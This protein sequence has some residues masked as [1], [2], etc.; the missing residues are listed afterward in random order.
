MINKVQIADSSALPVR[1]TIIN[2]I[3]FLPTFL[4]N[5]KVH[6]SN[7]LEHE[8]NLF[9]KNRLSKF[10]I[11]IP[12]LF[13]VSQGQIYIEV[14]RQTEKNY[15]RGN[16][17]CQFAAY[18]WVIMKK[19]DRKYKQASFLL[20]R[21]TNPNWKQTFWATYFSMQQSDMIWI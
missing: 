9:V 1:I 4:R 13:F 3:H 12:M 17:W 20:G 14:V 15:T 8:R 2:L 18:H 21:K 16:K 19:H 5:V 6:Q 11:K 7:F 10:P